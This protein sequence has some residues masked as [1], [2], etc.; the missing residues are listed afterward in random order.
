MDTLDPVVKVMAG[1]RVFVP[2]RVRQALGVKV[3]DSVA[4]S[5][6]GG[7]VTLRRVAGSVALVPESVAAKPGAVTMPPPTIV[8]APATKPAKDPDPARWTG[9]A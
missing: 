3:G 8:A 9:I 6:V 4:F 2:A 7:A 1:G 5:V